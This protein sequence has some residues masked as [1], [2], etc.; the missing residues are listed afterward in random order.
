MELGSSISSEVP[1]LRK[2]NIACSCLYLD[3]NL[4]FYVF[5]LM[6]NE[7]VQRSGSWKETHERRKGALRERSGEGLKV[8]RWR[9]EMKGSNQGCGGGSTKNKYVWK[10]HKEIFYFV[11]QF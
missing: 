4:K 5:V 3:L 6:G 11:S 9:Q 7:C 8:E 10:C 2:I 1:W